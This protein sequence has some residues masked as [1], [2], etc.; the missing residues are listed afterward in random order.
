VVV[1][2]VELV[3]LVDAVGVLGAFSELFP[4]TPADAWDPYRDLYPE[5]FAAGSWHILCTCY[6][7]RAG[8]RTVL[9]DTG[10]GPPGLWDWEPEYEGELLPRCPRTGWSWPTSMSS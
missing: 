4:E 9:V 5:L 1:G 6:L 8:D 7:V 3:P 2:S 10:V